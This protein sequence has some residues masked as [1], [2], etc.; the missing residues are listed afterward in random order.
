[1]IN[2]VRYGFLGYT[3]ANVA[4]SLGVLTARHRRAVRGEPA[5][6][7][8]RLQAARV[9]DFLVKPQGHPRDADRGVRAAGARARP[10]AAG[11]RQLRADGEQRDLRRVR[12]PHVLLG[13]LPGRGRL[14]ARADVGLRRRGAR[15]RPTGSRRC[16]RVRLPAAVVAP[17]GDARP[18]DDARLHGRGSPH[19]KALPATYQRYSQVTGA[20]PFY[21]EDTEALQML[22]RPLFF[23]SFLIDDQ[24]ADDGLTEQGAD[25]DLQRVEQD[26]DRRRVPPGAA[27]GRRA[28]GPHLAAATRSSWRASASTTARSRTTRSARSSEAPRRSWTSP[29]DGDVRGGGAQPP[30]R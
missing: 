2:L 20:D 14:G 9:T 19:R 30:R 11:G 8:D 3:E 28:G 6:V 15:A 5:P 7:P 23:T 24:L 16:A 22:L 10:G 18:C 1:M 25:R 21:R 29:G 27:R 4:L 12:R 26:G 13:L 17:G